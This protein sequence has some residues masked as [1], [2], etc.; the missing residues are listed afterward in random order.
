MARAK[1][2]LAVAIAYTGPETAAHAVHA[3]DPGNENRIGASGA[4]TNT[5][6]ARTSTLIAAKKTANPLCALTFCTDR[7]GDPAPSRVVLARA[8]RAA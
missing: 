8:P 7:D 4:N 5:N 2:K 6:H 3:E 1:R